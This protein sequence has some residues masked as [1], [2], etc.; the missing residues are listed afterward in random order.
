MYFLGAGDGNFGTARGY[1]TGHLPF[2]VA[3]GDV[4]GDGKLDLAT[5]NYYGNT[6]SILLGNGD[7]SFVSK[8]PFATDKRPT[9]IAIANPIQ[10]PLQAPALPQPLAAAPHLLSITQA[11][12][13]P[14]HIKMAIGD[15]IE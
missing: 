8:I 1:A 5:P 14:D 7:G 3:V 4:N 13:V 10:D 2:M 11:D 6:I 9:Q 15:G 12:G